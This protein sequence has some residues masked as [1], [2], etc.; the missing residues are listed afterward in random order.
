MNIALIIER[1]DPEGGGAE[2]ST[3]QI[4]RQLI[5]RGHNVTVLAW[6]A[7]TPCTLE[8][9]HIEV[10]TKRSRFNSMDRLKFAR[11][12][13]NQLEQGE[14]DTSLSVT[15]AAPAAVVQPRGGTVRE[16]LA[17]NVAMRSTAAGRGL[18]RIVQAMT[19]RY[20]VQ[21][22]LERKTFI[23]PIVRHFAAVS[24]YVGRQLQEHYAIDPPRITVIPN[25]SEMPEPSAAER[26]AWRQRIREGFGIAEHEPTFLFAAHNPKLK[27]MDTLLRAVRLLND[28]GTSVTVMVAGRLY[29]QFQRQ[30]ADL[31]VRR[32]I[33]FV[34]LTTRMAPLYCAADVTVL[35][36]FYDPSSKVVIESLMLGVPAI[37]T[38]FNGASAYLEEGPTGRVVDD[39]ADAAA[40]ADAMAELADPEIR[41]KCR[42]AASGLRERL[43]MSRHVDELERLLLGC[44]APE[45]EPVQADVA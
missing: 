41:G 45:A 28:R 9:G 12:A 23:D 34:G 39:P 19:P 8:G 11:W 17:R 10:R 42:E 35:P 27:G 24:A 36:S 38:A 29:Y 33:R 5:A 20:A 1:F 16:T 2:R 13:R 32:Q 25:A 40:L 15:T 18:K 43:S 26:S 37:S 22:H 14:F 4:A 7:R 44:A 21:R 6:T 30:A 31:D 3:D